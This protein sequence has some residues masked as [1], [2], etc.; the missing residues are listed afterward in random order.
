MHLLVSYRTTSSTLASSHS[1]CR[2]FVNWSSYLFISAI[3]CS[4][5][6]KCS[7]LSLHWSLA[8]LVSS[9][10]VLKSLRFYFV[11][12]S[13]PYENFA[14]SKMASFALNSLICEFAWEACIL[15][16]LFCSAFTF[17][18]SSTFCLLSCCTLR[19]S[20]FFYY[21]NLSITYCCYARLYF[22]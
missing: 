4:L 11:V 10:I 5:Y 21:F 14:C 13:M 17:R 22:I 16:I 18:Y 3:S 19:C 6:A 7:S 9:K 15:W 1:V 8:Y 12:S 20:R 2:F